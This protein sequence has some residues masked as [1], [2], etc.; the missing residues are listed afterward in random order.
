MVPCS[1]T[2]RR[3]PG[4]HVQPVDV[5]GDDAGR[6][7]ARLEV[8]EREVPG[9]RLGGG[10]RAPAE[11]AADPVAAPRGVAR[12]EL[13]DGH[14]RAHGRALAAVVG[15]AGVGRDAGAGEHRDAATGEGGDGLGHA[16]RSPRRRAR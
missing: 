16:R 13:V 10:E 14:R 15:D 1:S 9:V 5:L 3:L 7:A 4:A 12:E 6:D 8:G 2:T 11:V